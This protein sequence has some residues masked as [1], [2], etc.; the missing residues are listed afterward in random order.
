MPSCNLFVV[1]A[2]IELA[3]LAYQARVINQYTMEPCR[4]HSL[5][6]AAFPL[7]YARLKSRCGWIRTNDGC[8]F[9]RC[10]LY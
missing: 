3:S 2:R 4:D 1:P 6:A 9:K 8:L 5:G 10:V 7:G